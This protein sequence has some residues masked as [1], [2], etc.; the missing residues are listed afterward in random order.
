MASTLAN[1]GGSDATAGIVRLPFPFRLAWKLDQQIGTFRCHRRLA[2]PLTAIFDE[3]ARHHGQAE[4]ECLRL[5]I[6]GGC[7]NHRTM[8]GG[9][10]LSTHAWGA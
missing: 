7:F 10:A 5:H 9:T 6:W 2:E 8:R 1:V 3:T 4:M